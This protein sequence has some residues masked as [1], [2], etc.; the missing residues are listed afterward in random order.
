MAVFQELGASS[1][2][3]VILCKKLS[4]SRRIH[5]TTS[6]GSS[7]TWPRKIQCFLE[8]VFSCIGLGDYCTIP[9]PTFPSAI[10]GPLACL[11]TGGLAVNPS[12]AGSW[13]TLGSTREPSISALGSK[14]R[15]LQRETY[16]EQK[17]VLE[18]F[19]FCLSG[20]FLPRKQTLENRKDPA[21]MK[22]DPVV[23]SRSALGDGSA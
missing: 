11:S 4:G 17:I 7:G 23:G 1:F 12:W 2:L 5:G 22:K 10:L 15:S 18:D 13:S 14:S 8:V 19:E 9:W 3:H 20:S 21:F 6:P 16:A